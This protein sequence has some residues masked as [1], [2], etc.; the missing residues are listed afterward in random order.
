MDPFGTSML[1][2][3]ARYSMDP[4][5]TSMLLEAVI[6]VVPR[7]QSSPGPTRGRESGAYVRVRSSAFTYSSNL[8]TKLRRQQTCANNTSLEA[9]IYD[10]NRCRRPT[11][12]IAMRCDTHTIYAG[13]IHALPP[14]SQV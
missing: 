12:L 13:V 5:G 8:Q 2:E 11:P 1:L 10:I 7:Y 6:T 14:L 3:D 9:V 4:F